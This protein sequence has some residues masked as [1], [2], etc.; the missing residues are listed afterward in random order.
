[1]SRLD[2]K[3]TLRT[4]TRRLHKFAVGL[5][6]LTTAAI[7]PDVVLATEFNYTAGATCV[8]RN[9]A[10]EN[11]IVRTANS[12]LNRSSTAYVQ[13]YC[14]GPSVEF[15]DDAN[16]RFIVYGKQGDTTR[17]FKAAF[18]LFKP[19]DGALLDQEV[20]RAPSTPSTEVRFGT[21]SALTHPHCCAYNQ[22]QIWIPP[23]STLYNVY[24]VYE[25]SRPTERNAY[26]WANNPTAANYTPAEDYSYNSTGGVNTIQRLGIGRYRVIM[27][28]AGGSEV[29]G[30]F[31]VTAHAVSAVSCH[32]SGWSGRTDA[33]ADVRCYKTDG[34]AIDSRFSVRYTDFE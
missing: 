17:F 22:V 3:N 31:Q 20:V 5:G 34:T 13:V 30:N 6:L 16:A 7:L 4:K 24:S 19:D 25:D 1:M 32:L 11:N 15:P 26:V 8:A 29:G 9:A 28:G 21:A 12:M 27:P 18:R 2:I 10:S 23:L 33:F 14:S